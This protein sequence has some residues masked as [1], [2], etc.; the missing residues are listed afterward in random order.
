[1]SAWFFLRG[2]VREAGHWGGFLERFEAAFPGARAIPLEIPGN[3]ARFRE[4]SPLTVE[5]MAEAVRAEFLL[6]RT[7]HDH[8]F[9]L[10]LGGMIGL[11]WMRRW[12]EDFRSAALV[13]TSVRGLSPL[14]LRLRTENYTSI[15][16]MFLSGDP[17]FVEQKI[18]ELTSNRHKEF[19]ALASEWVK[20]TEVRP[21]APANAL[22]QLV[23]AARFRPPHSKPPVPS[24]VL[25]G[26]GDRLVDPR[27]SRAIA[28]KWG[29]KLEAHPTAGHDLTLDEP[30]WV[31]AKIRDFMADTGR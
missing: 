8:L 17:A 2:L 10:S 11:E 21:V 29:L 4:K 19:S 18:L 28:E 13:N 14:H 30:D 22:R 1:M 23:A 12:P 24:I 9:A 31:I 15:L 6:R 3:G 25:N 16:R 20:I 5:E 27:C 26:L 7:G